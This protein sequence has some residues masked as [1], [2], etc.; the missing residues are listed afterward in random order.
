VAG[1]GHVEV[2]AHTRCKGVDHLREELTMVEEKGGK[3]LMLRQPKSRYALRIGSGFT[4]AQQ[5][6]PPKVRAIVVYQFQEPSGRGHPHFPT[7]VGERIDADKLSNADTRPI[8]CTKSDVA[9]DQL[10]DDEDNNSANA[11]DGTAA[12][13]SFSSFFGKML[14][15][16]FAL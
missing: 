9:R 16:I 3:G 15:G 14:A 1:V 7:F 13:T 2:V 4:D 10:S 8:Q 5:R 12:T 6:R 11:N